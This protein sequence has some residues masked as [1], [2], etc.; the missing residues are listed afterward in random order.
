[1][2]PNCS[3]ESQHGTN[4]WGLGA[5]ASFDDDYRGYGLEK[6][7]NCNLEAI[8]AVLVDVGGEAM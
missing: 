3:F 6:R 1:M 4:C 2:D 8:D 5:T 7:P